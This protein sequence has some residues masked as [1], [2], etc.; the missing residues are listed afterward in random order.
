M[1]LADRCNTGWLAARP[2]GG[3]V[4]AVPH[5]EAQICC[6]GEYREQQALDGL[7]HEPDDNLVAG[8]AKPQLAPD[9]VNDHPQHWPPNEHLVPVC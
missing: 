7:F 9:V 2:A 1:D 3:L 8:E 5:L 4:S 6:Q